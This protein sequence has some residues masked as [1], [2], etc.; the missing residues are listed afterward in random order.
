MAISGEPHEANSGGRI[1]CLPTPPGIRPLQ[2]DGTRCV[3]ADWPS[4][5]SIASCPTDVPAPEGGLVVAAHHTTRTKRILVCSTPVGPLGSGIGGG[6]ELTL[7]GL[8]LGLSS[9]GHHV[10]VAAPAGSLHVGARVHQIPGNLQA[11]SQ[12]L[13]R[14]APIEMPPSPVLGAMWDWVREH[15]EHFDVVLNLAYD[16]LPYF[17][18]PFLDVP[19]AHLVSMGSVNDAMDSVLAE[20]LALRPGIA[21]VH[22]RA[23]AAT[24]PA[25]A[26]QLRVV[27]NGIAVERY[28]VHLSADEPA[29][30]GFIG[31]ISPEKGIEDVFAISQATGMP[32]KA[33]GLMQDESC[34]HEASARHPGAQVSYEGFLA[35]DDLQAAVGGCTGL[36]MT[37]KWVEAFGNV[38]IEAMA[39]GVPVIAYRRGGPSEIVVDGETGFLVDADDVDGAILAVG[40]LGEIDRVMCRQRVEE[41]FST[42]AFAER[43]DAW[44]DDLIRLRAHV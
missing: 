34:W 31:R 19:V 13:G 40:R 5:A 43:V 17:L 9:R 32:V 12:T 27:G 3:G 38:A 39:C 30:L 29:S 11:S 2:N 35:T 44:L 28:D 16:W 25:I 22:S 42:D 21:A 6:V 23:Q 4:E 7:H 26:D 37:P 33:W 14:D 18:T 20:L 10:D 36:L 8:V 1:A 15:Q 24:F 41:R